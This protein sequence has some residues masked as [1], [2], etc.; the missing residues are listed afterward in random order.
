MM[1]INIKPW[2]YEEIQTKAQKYMR[3]ICWK[4]QYL[5]DD[6]GE[7]YLTYSINVNGVVKETEKAICFDCNFW[8]TRG[9]T[10]NFTVYNGHK[11]WIPKS[12]IIEMA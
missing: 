11:V 1:N 4:K 10:A 7:E 12:A 6:N 2:I 8:S 9:Y 3:T 5:L